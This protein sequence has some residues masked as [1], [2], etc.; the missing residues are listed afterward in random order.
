MKV[1]AT[2]ISDPRELRRNEDE[3][4]AF[5]EEHSPNP[6][7]L[8]AFIAKLMDLRANIDQTPAVIV[9]KADDRIIGVAPLVLRR[10]SGIRHA[11][12]LCPY[13]CSPDFV[14]DRKYE[15]IALE[16]VIDVVIRRLGLRYLLLDFEADSPSLPALKHVCESEGIP[17][18]EQSNEAL[19]HGVISVN[20]SWE[21]YRESCGSRL[22][23]ELRNIENKLDREGRWEVTL[24]ADYEGYSV[25][26]LYDKVMAIEKQSWKEAY[27]QL[28][29]SSDYN[30]EWSLMSSSSTKDN[31]RFLRRKIW[32]LELEGK[33]V[34]YSIVLQYKGVAY[35]V[36]TAFVEA[37]SRL[38]LGRYII[39]AT[40]RDL[41]ED[42][43]VEKIDFQT[44]YP[45]VRS[46]RVN[47]VK[48]VRIRLGNR[49]IVYLAHARALLRR[50]INSL[51]KN[52]GR[53]EHSPTAR[54]QLTQ[55]KKR[56]VSSPS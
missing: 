44:Y 50:M 54:S 11:E 27:R 38:G 34:A 21:D 51:K 2:V 5:L 52:D 3:I 16:T 55:A 41:F 10:A 43:E 18:F 56:R 48:R 22:S 36:K 12:F 35:I 30:V 7:V 29:G 20:S 32:F 42:K 40:V 17:F 15:S 9:V 46:W 33:P 39:Y 49:A 26:A 25:E 28:T 53:A 13:A 14:L 45:I 8:F 31:I 19:D 23:R 1:Y 4:D 6:F 37:Y 24:V 47:C